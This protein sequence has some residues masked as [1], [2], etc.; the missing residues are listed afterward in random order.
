MCGKVGRGV[1]ACNDFFFTS[2]AFRQTWNVSNREIFE[3]FRK[4]L[5]RS[6]L[7]T[8]FRGGYWPVNAAELAEMCLWFY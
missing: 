6:A 5:V 3:K 7:A 1:C 8:R 2:F 4:H